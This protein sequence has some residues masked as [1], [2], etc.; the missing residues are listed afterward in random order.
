MLPRNP[1]VVITVS[2]VFWLY[3]ER[4]MFAEEYLRRAFAAEFVAWAAE[5]PAF[6]P[7]FARWKSAALR[8]AGGPRFQREY[9]GVFGLVAAFAVMACS[10]PHSTRVA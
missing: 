5:T 10:T 2:L 4:I 1:W 8:S 3:H 7:D 9:S 6:I